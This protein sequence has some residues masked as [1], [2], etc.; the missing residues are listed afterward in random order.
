MPHT[1]ATYRHSDK[2]SQGKGGCIVN[3]ETQ[4][5]FCA[6]TEEVQEFASKIARMGYGHTAV[7]DDEQDKIFEGVYKIDWEEMEEEYEFL[8]EERLELEKT[9]K[10]EITVTAIICLC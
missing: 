10:E 6:N 9:M 5:D 2:T 4:T 7:L 1:V 3:V 8:E